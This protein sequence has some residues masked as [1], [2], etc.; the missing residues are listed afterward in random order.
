VIG[1]CVIEVVQVNHG[2]SRFI[3][4]SPGSHG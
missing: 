4:A 1:T 2:E 3:V